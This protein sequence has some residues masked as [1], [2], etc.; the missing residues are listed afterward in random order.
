MYDAKRKKSGIFG[1]YVPQMVG[2]TKSFCQKKNTTFCFGFHSIEAFKSVKHNKI[3]GDSK[4]KKF[5]QQKVVVVPHLAMD[6][7]GDFVVRTIQTY[8]FFYAAPKDT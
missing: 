4:Q 3:S 7:G 6:G 8:H 5:P 1:W 2:L